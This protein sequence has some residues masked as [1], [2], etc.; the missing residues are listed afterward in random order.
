MQTSRD[1]PQREDIHVLY[2]FAGPHRR[3]DIRECLHKLCQEQ[4]VLLVVTELDIILHGEADDLSRDEVW[5][6]IV[7][8]L[9]QGEFNYLVALP[10]CHMHSSSI[11]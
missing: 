6:K 7:V 2:M 1:L 4:Q 11:L 8:R 10:P 9:Q 5:D 3:S